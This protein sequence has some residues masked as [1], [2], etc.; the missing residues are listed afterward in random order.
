MLSVV[1]RPACAWVW[2]EI[3]LIPLPA[4][5]WLG[6]RRRETDLQGRDRAGGRG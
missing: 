1:V 2:V 5:T 3:G 6:I 4:K